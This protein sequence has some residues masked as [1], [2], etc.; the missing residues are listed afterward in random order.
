MPLLFRGTATV[1]AN[2]LIRRSIEPLGDEPRMPAI[3]EN[4][5]VWAA[6]LGEDNTTPT[7][8]K[9]L[10]EAM[11]GVNWSTAPEPKRPRPP[12]ALEPRR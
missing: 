12:R 2:E 6:W 9:S 10:L 3:L 1:P 5:D 7:A 4:F 11:E 8:A